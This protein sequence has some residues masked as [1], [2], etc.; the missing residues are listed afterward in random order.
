M[1]V[2]DVLEYQNISFI[3]GN[4][5][6][7]VVPVEDDDDLPKD[8]TGASITWVVQGTIGGY[9]YIKKEVGSGIII[10]DLDATNDAFIVTFTPSDTENMNGIY[11]Y[12][13]AVKDST[14]VFST[15][16]RGKFIIEGSG[17]EPI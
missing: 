13:A 17:I 7:Y 9:E 15:V 10:V 16:I 2:D 12:E 6:S 5:K 3:A 8:L 11:Y 4:D 1:S 14:D